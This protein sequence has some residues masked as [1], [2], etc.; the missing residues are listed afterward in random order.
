MNTSAESYKTTPSALHYMLRAFWPSSGWNGQNGFPDLLLSWVGFRIDANDFD[1]LRHFAQHETVERDEWLYILAPHVFGFRLLMVML[2][3]PCWPLPIWG[4]LQVRNR[5][6]LHS[7]F[8]TGR[9]FNLVTRVSAWRVLEKGIE[10]DLY[11]RMEDGEVC[12]WESAVTFYYRG[13]YGA[14]TERGVALGA[15]SI[16][17]SVND[18]SRIAAEWRIDGSMR[19]RFGTLTGDYNGLHQSNWYAQ[20]FGFASAFA[21]PQRT[22]VQCLARLPSPGPTPQQLDLWIKGPVFFGGEAIL[23][24]SECAEGDGHDFGLRLRPD[25]RPALV[26]RWCTTRGN[27][28]SIIAAHP[29]SGAMGR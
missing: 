20:R 17:P 5:L 29:D 7:T 14:A 11:S 28:G 12:V 6:L 22:T 2:T 1:N 27:K 4:A 13:R 16:S 9:H 25:A 10:V 18:R 8:Q 15:P 21:H 26:G 23:H 19:W 24:Y 3:H